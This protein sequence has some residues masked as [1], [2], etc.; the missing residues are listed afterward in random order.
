MFEY[1]IIISVPQQESC[2]LCT[3]EFGT[4]MEMLLLHFLNQ[5]SSFN[6]LRQEQHCRHVGM[7]SQSCLQTPPSPGGARGAGTR[8]VGSISW[9]GG[10]EWDRPSGRVE[11]VMS[12]NTGL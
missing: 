3:T 2:A 1:V 6:W 7:E 12:V 11:G 5:R 4:L 9:D 8:L 10:L